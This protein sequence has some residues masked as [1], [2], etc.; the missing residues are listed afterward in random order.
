M[1]FGFPD[2]TYHVIL[3]N[4]KTPQLAVIDA[5]N[6]LRTRYGKEVEDLDEIQL[7]SMLDYAFNELDVDLWLEGG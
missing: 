2:D 4:A 7:C 5:R 3:S 1:T 6:V